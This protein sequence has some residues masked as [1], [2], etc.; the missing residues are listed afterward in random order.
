M[1]SHSTIL[2]CLVLLGSLVLLGCSVGNRGLARM[3][4]TPTK[5]PRSISTATLTPTATRTALPT[6]TATHLPPTDTLPPPTATSEPT[7][8]PVLA[9]N[10][11]VSAS[12]TPLPPTST[13]APPSQTPKPAPTHTPPAPTQTPAPQLDFL[14]AEVVAFE[15][16]SL[17]ASGLHNIYFTVVDAAGAPINGIILEET[18]N[19]PTI[20]VVSG[21]KGPGMAEFTMW[22]ADY[23]FRVV[24]DTGGQAFTSE[25]THI[26]SVL[27]GRAVWEDLIRGGICSD[28]VSCEALGPIHYSYRVKFQRTW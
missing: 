28:P 3:T 26:L 15:D 7:D 5:T 1:K 10:T 14:V 9:T 20:Q 19:Q 4:P 2:T 11:P 23:Q 6:P 17:S 8:T 24:G 12:D 16:G 18:S 21:D 27:F 13:E 22:A 25:V